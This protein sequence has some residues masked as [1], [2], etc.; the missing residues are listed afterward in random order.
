MYKS[1]RNIQDLHPRLRGLFITFDAELRAA[2]VDYIVTCTYRNG[3]DQDALY[4]QGRTVRG[5]KVTNA[6]AGESLHNNCDANGI[7]AA[8]AFDIV[9]MKNGKPDWNV[10]NPHWKLAGKIG[11]R[12][13][14]EWAGNWV[15]F[16]EYPHFQ[17]PKD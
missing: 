15:S 9:I 13:G 2:G 12:V 3:A 11:Q 5:N 6:K 4:A 10:S 17:L 1:S 16:K 8:R 14:L 7:P